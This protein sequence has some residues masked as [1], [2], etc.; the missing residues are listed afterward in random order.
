VLFGG[1]S[2]FI[3]YDNLIQQ[4]LH[5]NIKNNLELV[6]KTVNW[7]NQVQYWLAQ[8]EKKNISVTL[9]Y[10]LNTSILVLKDSDKVFV[11]L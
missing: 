11:V 10:A 1:S 4:L 8:K 9:N 3:G 7:Q 2:W 5:K 6:K